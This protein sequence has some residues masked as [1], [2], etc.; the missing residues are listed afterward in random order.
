MLRYFLLLFLFCVICACETDFDITS[1]WKEVPIVY[2][3]LD[4]S[5]PV[6]Y[7]RINKSY[8]GETDA[9]DAA[10]VV[11][12]LYFDASMEV[13]LKSFRFGVG[14]NPDDPDLFNYQ[15]NINYDRNDVLERVSLEEEG[16]EKEEG[17]FVND[18]AYVYKYTRTLE[19]D[20]GYVLEFTIPS[21][22]KIRA[23]TPIVE[24][25]IIIKPQENSN[26]YLGISNNSEE[27]EV[28]WR[29]TDNASIFDITFHLIYS[30]SITGNVGDKT[31]KSVFWTPVRNF[32]VRQEGIV[33]NSYLRSIPKEAFYNYLNSVIPKDDSKIRFLESM[34][35]KVMGANEEYG[36]YINANASQASIAS[37]LVKP[38]YSNINGGLGVFSSVSESEVLISQFLNLDEWAC[39]YEMI[40]ELNFA[41][42]VGS[43]NWPYC[44]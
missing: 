40:S 37:G 2:G 3:L 4:R 18:P 6:Q 22:E 5:K 13:R 16:Y 25:I 11:D 31:F 35:F 36:N 28:R 21:G 14:N 9:F 29:N 8:L 41:P 23:F 30:E 19:E 26:L 33:S 34:R 38:E 42:S 17:T 10:Q 1:E 20:R 24:D 43:G 15:S 44:F 7:I 12:S 39:E 27:F 32:D